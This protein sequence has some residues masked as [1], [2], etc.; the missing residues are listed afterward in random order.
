MATTYKVL[1]QSAPGATTLVPL[2]I[3]PASTQAVLSTL[4][5]CNRGLSTGTFSITVQP[6]GNAVSSQHYIAYEAS[7]AANDSLFLTIGVTLGPTDV[8]SVYASSS[9][10]SFGAFGSETA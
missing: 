7:I 2:Y 1:G 6:F 4:S 8:V 9:A 3:V 10:F 5:V